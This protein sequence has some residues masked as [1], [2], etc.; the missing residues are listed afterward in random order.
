MAERRPKWAETIRMFV[1]DEIID[2]K[3]EYPQDGSADDLLDEVERAVLD[4]FCNAY[5][6][7]IIDDQCMI[8][9]HRYCIYCGRRETAINWGPDSPGYDEMGQ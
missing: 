3:Y 7:E 5:G 2:E 8:P 4:I 9:A 1:T 6:H